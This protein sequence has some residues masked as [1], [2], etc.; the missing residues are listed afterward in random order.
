MDYD[1]VAKLYLGD[2]TICA[3]LINYSVFKGQQVVTPDCL[4]SIDNEEISSSP[5]PGKDHFPRRRDIL[6]NVIIKHDGRHQY[7]LFGIEHQSKVNVD[8]VLRILEYDIMRYR[9]E[10]DALVNKKTKNKGVF[11]KN[12]KLPL[13]ITI[14]VYFG[15]RPWAGPLWFHELIDADMPELQEFA[16]KYKLHILQPTQINKT[17]ISL[18]KSE[19]ASFLRYIQAGTNKTALL[20]LAKEIPILSQAAVNLINLI[21]KANIDATAT[22]EGGMV[23]MYKGFRAIREDG[24]KI[25][26]QEGYKEGRLEIVKNM[27]KLKKLSLDE[28]ASVS[29]FTLAEIE[30]VAAKS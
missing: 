8:M 1:S 25:G 4:T 19:F 23:D 26:R 7:L 15:K 29:G 2:N 16:P 24:V 11:T 5:T 20:K 27:L 10:R 9:R 12:D 22:N 30:A 3:D 18:F 28:I 13:I 14:V 21:T 17:D 6:K